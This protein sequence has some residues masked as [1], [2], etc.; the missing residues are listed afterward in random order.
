[1]SSAEAIS[2]SA[3]FS[4]TVEGTLFKKGRIQSKIKEPKINFATKDMA[5]WKDLITFLNPMKHFI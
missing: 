3:D 5:K 1:M 4:F 2:S